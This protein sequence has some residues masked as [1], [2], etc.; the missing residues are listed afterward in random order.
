MLKV[1]FFDAAGT[2][3]EPREPVGL[4]YVRIAREYGVAAS[5]ADVGA[6]FRRAFH[7]A[8]PLAFGPG[9]S[10]YDLRRL[11]R[12][13]WHDLV[14]ATFAE[15]GEFK[16]FDAYFDALFAFFANPAHWIADA[17]AAPT[18]ERLKD[19]GLALGLISNFDHRLYRILDGLGL[20]RYFDSVT[21][22]SEAGYAKPAPELFKVA[23]ARHSV[24][25]A[26]AL[27]VGDSEHLDLAGAAAAGIAAV[28]IE[29]NASSRLSI[30]ERIARVSSLG[31]VLE[32]AQRLPFP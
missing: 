5:V 22:S 1:I 14:A 30:A 9:R 19:S 15:L 18:L 32:A 28:L 11:E 21:I 3:F 20:I 10:A 16:D 4:S 2:L 29:P 23:L 12:Q 25:P 27:H 26:E 8:P 17:D 7:G 31:A 24:E 6:R 13:W